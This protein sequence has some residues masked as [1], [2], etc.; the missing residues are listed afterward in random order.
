MSLFSVE[1]EDECL[2]RKKPFGKKGKIH[3][4][5]GNGWPKLKEQ[6]E[7]WSKFIKIIMNMY[8]H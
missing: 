8:I 5:G 1:E 6:A 2:I 4:F 3:C 7:E